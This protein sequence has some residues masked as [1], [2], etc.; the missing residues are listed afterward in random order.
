MTGRSHLILGLAAGAAYA[1]LLQPSLQ[2]AG[3]MMLAGAIGGL[4]PDADC[5]KSMINGYIPGSG[6]VLGLTGIRH[7]T[8]THS[9]PF[10]ALL[11]AVWFAASVPIPYP[12]M[13]AGSAGFL[14]HIAADMTTSEGVPLFY[15][16]RFNW[17]ILPRF[18]LRY[19]GAW[20]LETLASAGGLIVIVGAI[21]IIIR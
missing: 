14:S 20:I 12:L 3:L 17:R 1:A 6:I 11:W 8:F 13:L 5:P 21:Y 2:S 9:L 4:L 18:M 19:G 7:R 15:P 10:L 16:I